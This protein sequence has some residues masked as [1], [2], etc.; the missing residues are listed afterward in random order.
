LWSFLLG[1]W[2]KHF[3]PINDIKD[4]IG[5]KQAF[6][7]AWL[8]HYTSWLMVPFLGGLILLAVQVDQYR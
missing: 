8:I 4:Y 3:V 7:V 2:K 1:G 6:Y 5:E